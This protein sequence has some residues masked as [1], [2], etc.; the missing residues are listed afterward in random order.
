M[1][2]CKKIEKQQQTV[3]RLERCLAREKLKN[4]KADT[5]R[6]I[7]FGGLVIKA[8]MDEY[9]KDI[10]LGALIKARQEIERDGSARAL[11]KSIGQAEF[12]EY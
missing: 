5:R 10:I 6:K 11:L 9:P 1:S 4:R 7:Q 8:G 12:M 2:T 3:A